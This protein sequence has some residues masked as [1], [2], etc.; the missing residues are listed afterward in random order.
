[1]FGEPDRIESHPSGGPYQRKPHEGGGS[2]S[3]YPFEVWEYRHI[4]GV[5][6]DVEL[7]FVNDAGG[8][9]Y[10]LTLDPQAKDEL[11]HIPGMGLT[12]SELLTGQK[13]PDRVLG[14]RDA[15]LAT[16]QGINFERAKDSPFER[17]E[18]LMRISK[19]P[20]IRFNDL[21][22]VVTASVS[23]H[24][25]PFRVATH[26][27]QVGGDS[28]V[29]PVTVAFDN[30][31]VSFKNQEGL[32]HSRLQVYGRVTTLTRR[33]VS[34]F[35]DEIASDYGAAEID[36]ARRRTGAYQH[37]LVLRPGR[38]KLDLVLKDA[39]S[40][41]VGTTST[42]LEVPAAAQGRLAT[43]SVVLCDEIQTADGDLSQPFVLGFYKVRP[44]LDRALHS[45]EDFGFY[46]E[47]YNFALDQ[48][49]QAPRLE[50]RYGFAAPGAEP[51]SYR[52]VTR[53]V[54]FTRDRIAVARMTQ[55][56]KLAPGRYDLV[57]AIR[58][59]ITGQSV[60]TRTPLEVK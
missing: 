24:Q 10:R 60:T 48:A 29:V 12:D 59:T 57:F 30:G 41:R 32:W 52:P 14:I 2:T 19:A 6:D 47:A 40:G 4:D 3:T 21:R 25:L 9:M 44:R 42:G 33:I 38:Y 45:G 53:G 58:D 43:S 51:A 5:G 26:F 13:N 23:F 54:T 8:N 35:D 56:P 28:F 22:E 27:I 34:E 49:S 16:N 37:K 11:L 50:L 20:P 17:A 55:L 36:G 39:G 7:E 1:M 18:L 31:D 15:G 46:V